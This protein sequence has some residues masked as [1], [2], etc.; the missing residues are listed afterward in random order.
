VTYPGGADA[1]PLDVHRGRLGVAGEHVRFPAT[2]LATP[3]VVALDGT[4]VAVPSADDQMVLQ[5][6]H[7][8]YGRRHIR[9]GDLVTTVA[10]IR[11]DA[12]DW[13]RVLARSAETGTKDGL[14]CYLRYVEA[15][16]REVLDRPLLDPRLAARLDQRHWGAASLRDGL[17][18]FPVLRVNGRLF[19]R[20]LLRQVRTHNWLAAA[21]LCLVPA[22][23]AESSVRRLARRSGL[24]ASP[25]GA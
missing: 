1:V 24:F 8:V 14:S 20:A 11:R 16:H 10:A 6:M 12:L 9:L 13:D 2:L 15:I 22:V 21:R 19:P 4:P 3:R 5:G 23:V 25:Q 18:R 7:R 17:V